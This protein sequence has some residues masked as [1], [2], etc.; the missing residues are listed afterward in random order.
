MYIRKVD[1]NTVSCIER[2]LKS[3]AMDIEGT[4]SSSVCL[5]AVNVI[6]F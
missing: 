5:H 2:I 1:D 6:C 4:H 3:Q